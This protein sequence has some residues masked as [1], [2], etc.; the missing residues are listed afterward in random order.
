[1]RT[2]A[3]SSMIRIL[4][5]IIENTFLALY[6]KSFFAFFLLFYIYTRSG[7]AI[8]VSGKVLAFSSLISI[9]QNPIFAYLDGNF[10]AFFAI[11]PVG[12]TVK[13]GGRRECLAR[14]VHVA[15]LQKTS[16]SS[17]KLYP[18]VSFCCCP[19]HQPLPLRPSY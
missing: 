18:R 2:V 4:G 10:F 7:Y 14:F 19:F 3:L 9:R 15:H 1:M 6:L 5:A 12:I 13:R 11:M 17:G 8:G 16:S